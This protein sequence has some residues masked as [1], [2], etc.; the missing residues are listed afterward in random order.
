MDKNL[1][2]NIS[3]YVGGI[4][5]LVVG[6]FYLTFTDIFIGNSSGW[7]FLGAIFSLGSAIFF[8]FGESKREKINQYETF[9]IIGI[10]L[11]VGFAVLL[12]IFSKSE[13]YL[14]VNFK[15]VSMRDFTF[16]TA[17]VLSVL[18]SI[19][20]TF[21]LVYDLEVVMKNE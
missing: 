19:T 9:K 4:G 17:L 13:L 1:I 5:M 6:L 21:N 15:K 2:K 7:L 14:N 18:F 12:I 8:L 16:V 3:C 11:A 20:Q 10:V